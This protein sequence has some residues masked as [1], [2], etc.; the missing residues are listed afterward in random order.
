MYDKRVVLDFKTRIFLMHVS[1]RQIVVMPL[2]VLVRHGQ[3]TYNLENRFTG[4]T[5]VPLTPRGREE[6]KAAGTKLKPIPFTR[7]YTSVLQRAI[8]TMT[9]LLETA[10]QPELPVTRDRALNE[11]NYGRLQGLDKAAIAKEYGAQQVAIW[12]RSFSVRPPGGES[13]ADTYHRVIP[14]YQKNIEPRVRAGNILIVA[15]GNSLRALMMYLEKI[16]EED[17]AHIDLPTGQPRQYQLDT[18]AVLRNVMDL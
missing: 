6:A 5:D 8:E 18:S 7:G 9:L 3:S 4:E 16:S 1:L 14:Y 17:I 15:H 11:R 2:L 10:G 12:R 13:L